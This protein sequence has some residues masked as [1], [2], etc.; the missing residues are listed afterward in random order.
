MSLLTLGSFEV[1]VGIVT[2]CIP[3]LRPGY[4]W[5]SERLGAMKKTQDRL[6]LAEV[7]LNGAFDSDTK[8][9]K[10]LNSYAG[11]VSPTVLTYVWHNDVQAPDGRIK[12][13]TQV[14]VERFEQC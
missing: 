2:A 10:P 8:V 4:R 13:T 9:A 11:G 14:D 5:I 12:K 1:N 7:P 3:T 6:P